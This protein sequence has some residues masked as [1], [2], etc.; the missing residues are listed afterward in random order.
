MISKN[1]TSKP[2][3]KN[4]LVRTF[5]S[6]R[7]RI[8]VTLSTSVNGAKIASLLVFKGKKAGEKKKN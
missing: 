2:G 6:V 4:I 8:S 7:T 3:Y 1:T 5:G